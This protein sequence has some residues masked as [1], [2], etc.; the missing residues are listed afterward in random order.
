MARYTNLP[1]SLSETKEN[2]KDNSLSDKVSKIS[3]SEHRVKREERVKDMAQEEE[4]CYTEKVCVLNGNESCHI[5]YLQKKKQK[6]NQSLWHH[7][8]C[9]CGLVID[10]LFVYL[11]FSLKVFFSAKV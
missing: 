3:K 4:E 5:D 6:N 7:F 9:H 10:W 2:R 11:F 8:C 1:L